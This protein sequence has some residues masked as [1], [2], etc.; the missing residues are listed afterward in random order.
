M[1][2]LFFL[3]IQPRA[4]GKWK[5][6]QKCCVQETQIRKSNLHGVGFSKM[7]H[8][9]GVVSTFLSIAVSC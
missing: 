3:W 7:C 4:F 5:V 2:T 9:M 1:G 6:N 8:K